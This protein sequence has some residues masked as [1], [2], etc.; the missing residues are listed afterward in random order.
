M[1][2]RAHGRAHPFRLVQRCPGKL[3]YKLG[4]VVLH[5]C[6][7]GFD[8]QSEYGPYGWAP[9]PGI[10]EPVVGR[11]LVSDSENAIF[12]GVSGTFYPTLKGLG[13]TFYSGDE[14]DFTRLWAGGKQGTNKL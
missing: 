2:G 12:Y 5:V 8:Y 13:I 9:I 14:A 4:A 10:P 7:G 1:E 6:N 11:D 3:Y